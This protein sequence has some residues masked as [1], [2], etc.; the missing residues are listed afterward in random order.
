M[1]KIYLFYTLIVVFF[2]T[3]CSSNDDNLTGN[4]NTFPIDNT[5]PDSAVTG[6]EYQVQISSPNT[7]DKTI[8]DTI[9][10]NVEFKSNTGNIVHYIEIRIYNKLD[11][12]EIYKKPSNTH[13]DDASGLYDFSDNFILS[14]NN[15]VSSNTDWVLEA[16][17][18]INDEND[19]TK[20]LEFHVQ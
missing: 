13:V 19:V 12:T 4:S 18:W 16:R 2:L 15:G 9:S 3:T 8:D 17:V 5:T 20:T 14:A 10:I 1:K 7:A 6:F 11:Q